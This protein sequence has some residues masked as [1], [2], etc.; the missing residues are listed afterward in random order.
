MLV[1]DGDPQ[2]VQLTFIPSTSYTGPTTFLSRNGGVSWKPSDVMLQMVSAGTAI[3]AL[4]FVNGRYGL[5]VGNTQMSSWRQLDAAIQSAGQLVERIWINPQ[6]GAL[7]AATW[8]NPE[9]QVFNSIPRFDAPGEL[10]GS[11]NSG[12]TWK[13]LRA[14]T[15]F[16]VA[17]APAASNAAWNVCGFDGPN[18]TRKGF[19]ASEVAC[20]ADGGQ[21]WKTYAIGPTNRPAQLDEIIGVAAD[22]SV[23]ATAVF[24]EQHWSILRYVP[25]DTQWR[26]LRDSTPAPHSLDYWYALSTTSSGQNVLCAYPLDTFTHPDQTHLVYTATYP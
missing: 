17:T 21:T 6:T 11:P 26:T 4:R 12:K 1:D 16:Y 15:A 13:L 14:T 19:R 25:G 3:Y 24:D 22:G 20:S 10:W 7:L 18:S 2:T 5:Y 23:L 9:P 8:L